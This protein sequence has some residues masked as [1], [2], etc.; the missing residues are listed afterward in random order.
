MTDRVLHLTL[1]SGEVFKVASGTPVVSL[2]TGMGLEPA[3]V[4]VR[5]NNVTVPPW[6]SLRESAKVT[7]IT[8]DSCEGEEILWR[9]LSFLIGMALAQVNSKMSAFV[10]YTLPDSLWLRITGDDPSSISL[11]ALRATMVELIEGNTPIVGREPSRDEALSIACSNE[12]SSWIELLELAE[13]SSLILHRCGNYQ[14]LGIHPLAASSGAIPSP[15][16]TSYRG[17]VILERASYNTSERFEEGDGRERVHRSCHKWMGWSR[18]VGVSTLSELIQES[19]DGKV[20]GYILQAEEFCSTQIAEIANRIREKLGALRMIRI[21][22]PSSSGKTT[23]TK[24]LVSCL[25]ESGISTYTIGMDNYFVSWEDTPLNEDGDLDFDNPLSVDAALLNQ[26]LSDLLAGRTIRE[27]TF[28]F[29]NGRRVY[30]GKTASLC[31]NGVVVMEGIHG[32]NPE[33][34]RKISQDQVFGIYVAPLTELSIHRGEVVSAADMR[35]VR[36]ILRDSKYRGYSAATTLKRWDAVRRSEKRHIF[37]FQKNADEVF[38]S[39]L[40]YDLG[41]MG[42]AVIELLREVP[43]DEEIHG[44]AQRLIALLKLFPPIPKTHVPENSILR[45]FIG[46]SSFEY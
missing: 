9:S 22:G 36:R 1:P 37:P 14:E 35:L 34:C 33:M 44:T 29:R 31:R 28:D 8:S 39:S 6:M 26:A 11:D 27:P 41:V 16:L 10:G 4:G 15:H 3:P 13:P 38:D 40:G 7:P 5:I 12:W 42:E 2:L 17:G 18:G 25:T 23:F 24:R 30:T 21:S 46:G 19:A 32:L 45:E 43:E 20:S